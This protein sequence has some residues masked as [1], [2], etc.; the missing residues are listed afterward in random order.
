MSTELAA[1]IGQNIAAFRKNQ[2]FSQ[3][4]LAEMVG[5]DTVSLS[6]IERGKTSASL[7]T[8][9]KIAECLDIP[10]SS[11][12]NGASGKNASLA[13]S[14]A[15]LLKDLGEADRLFLLEQLNAWVIKLQSVRRKK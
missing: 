3:A 12:L 1:R 14:V 4:S 2:M 11:L 10:L 6:R 8:L 5:I 13:E 7:S 9:E 15:I